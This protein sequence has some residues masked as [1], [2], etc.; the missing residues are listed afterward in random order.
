MDNILD[1]MSNKIQSIIKLEIAIENLEGVD[2]ALS[3]YDRPQLKAAIKTVEDILKNL[4]KE[5]NNKNNEVL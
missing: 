5:L 1:P 2:Q 4:K 3:N